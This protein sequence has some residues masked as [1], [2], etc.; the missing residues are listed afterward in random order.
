MGDYKSDFIIGMTMIII[1]TM[2]VCGLVTMHFITTLAESIPV[3][4]LA[5][6]GGASFVILSLGAA[7]AGTAWVNYRIECRRE[8]NYYIVEPPYKHKLVDGGKRL[9]GRGG[10]D[11]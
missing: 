7:K 2:F 8:Q 1:M 5:A 4:L 3:V 6:G 11:D 10:Y 9:L